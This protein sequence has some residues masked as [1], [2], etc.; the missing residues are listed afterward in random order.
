MVT[1]TTVYRLN[2][3]PLSIQCIVDG[4]PLPAVTWIRTLID[5]SKTVFSDGLTELDEMT[6]NISTVALN[7]TTIESFFL[8]INAT[9]ITDTLR[10]TCR[11]NNI[12]GSTQISAKVVGEFLADKLLCINNLEFL[13]KE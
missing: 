8:V 5:G 4:F 12:I 1:P 11:A 13:Q 10:F 6:F 7:I 3:A 2:S 9:N